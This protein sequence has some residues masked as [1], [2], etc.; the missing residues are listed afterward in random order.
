MARVQ[1]SRRKKASGPKNHLPIS[2]SIEPYSGS[3]T[4]SRFTLFEGRMLISKFGSRD[5]NYN[6]Y[7]VEIQVTPLA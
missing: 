7:N 5:K 4:V 6:S 1:P 3:L 2:R